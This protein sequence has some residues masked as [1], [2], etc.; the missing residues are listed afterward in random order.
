M[1]LESLPQTA[2]TVDML[3]DL[4]YKEWIDLR[5]HDFK[6][7]EFPHLL[8]YDL[9]EWKRNKFRKPLEEF[10]MESTMLNFI[11]EEPMQER[12][13][14]Y[15]KDFGDQA[16]KDFYYNAFMFINPKERLKFEQSYT[17]ALSCIL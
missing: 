4:C 9:L 14:S 2:E 17:P 15:Q 8:Q 3:L 11:I 16:D 5:A 6:G 10:P 12:I 1:D 13:R 7:Q